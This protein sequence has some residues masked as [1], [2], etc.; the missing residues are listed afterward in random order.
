MEPATAILSVH[1]SIRL[2]STAQWG[3]AV[4]PEKEWNED[5]S[6]LYRAEMSENCRYGVK[7]V[8]TVSGVA[9]TA[10][11]PS[12]KD[13]W[14]KVTTTSSL[15]TLQARR[16]CRCFWSLFFHPLEWEQHSDNLLGPSAEMSMVRKTTLNCY[17]IDGQRNLYSRFLRDVAEFCVFPSV[18]IAGTHRHT[19]HISWNTREE[20]TWRV[21]LQL[22][23]A[24]TL[25]I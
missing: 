11:H 10:Q 6:V 12:Q 22:H 20:G 21:I 4:L 5:S 16:F 9:R 17:P 2:H 23:L 7:I 14:T 8:I 25:K 13:E 3:D 19:Q 24:A 18:C 15:E 1:P